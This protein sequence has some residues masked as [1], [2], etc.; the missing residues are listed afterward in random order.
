MYQKFYVVVE[1][2]EVQEKLLL[3]HHADGRDM[4]NG[5]EDTPPLSIP[6]DARI[7]MFM[8]LHDKSQKA[9]QRRPIPKH[10]TFH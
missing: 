4:V 2:V 7:T 10:Y 3:G 9:T 1:T 5:Y 6:I 8:Q